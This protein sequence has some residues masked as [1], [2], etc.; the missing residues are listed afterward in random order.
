M[1]YKQQFEELKKFPETILERFLDVFEDD[2][3][4]SVIKKQLADTGIILEYNNYQIS[5]ASL[6]E[7]IELQK[8]FD[9][10]FEKV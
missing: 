3:K 6:D 9:K 1:G 4:I 8:Y 5:I 10:Y 2:S 7:L